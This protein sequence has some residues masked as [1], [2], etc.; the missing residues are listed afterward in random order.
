M[1]IKLS[2]YRDE[3]TCCLLKCLNCQITMAMKHAHTIEIFSAV[4]PLCRHV[5]DDIQIGKCHGCNQTIYD[6]NNVTDDVKRKIKDYGVTS[7]PT[8]I[9]RNIFCSIQLAD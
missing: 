7:V 3:C 4:C 1:M 5:I 8:I 2:I 9:I 6:I